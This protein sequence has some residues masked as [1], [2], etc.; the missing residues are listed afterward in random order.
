MVFGGMIKQKD[1]STVTDYLK[2]Y[3]EIIDKSKNHQL[4]KLIGKKHLNITREQLTN[5]DNRGV[6]DY[7]RKKVRK[8]QK[9]K[10]KKLNINKRNC[11]TFRR[12]QK[13]G[14]RT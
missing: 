10:K 2:Y 1:K 3:N 13:R 9:L 4:Y 5:T 11:R 7:V 8:L 12:L 6:R 14:K